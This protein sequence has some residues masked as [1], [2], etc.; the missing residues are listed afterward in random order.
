M[1]QLVIIFAMVWLTGTLN[2]ICGQQVQ[3]VNMIPNA[4]SNET[5][6]DSEPNLAINP[7]TPNQLVGS[8][9]TPNPLGVTS[10]PSAPIFFSQDGGQT[11]VLNAIVPSGSATFP[12]GDITVEF[13][14]TT[15]W[16]YS[17]ILRAPA[18]SGA[19]RTMDIFRTN[20]WVGT[21]L[22][23][24][25][26]TRNGPDQPY[27]YAATNPITGVDGLYVGNNDLS[28]SGSQTAAVDLSTNASATTPTL[29][30]NIIE[31]RTPS[32]QDGP[33]IR[34]AIH[35]SGTIYSIHTQRT[36][37]SG[38]VRTV[39]IV[40][41]RDDNWGGGAS[42][43][44]DLTDPSDGLSGRLAMTGVQLTWSGPQLGQERL[45]DRVAI[46]VDPNNAN[47]VY[48]AW[49]DNNGT[50]NANIHVRR[51]I[52]GGANWS[53]NDL[54]NVNSA[55]NPD[56]AI[57]NLGEVAL[58]YQNLNGTNW[59]TIVERTT[60]D[61]AT[62]ITNTLNSFPDGTP[63]S[64]FLPYIGDYAYL[65][66]QP[67]GKDFLGVFSASND[68]T[69]VRF[70]TVQPTWQRNIN[71]GT[72]S[73]RNLANTANVAVSID[74]FFYRVTPVA[75]NED[76]Y[77]RDWTKT[78]SD[79]DP[80]DEPS[81]ESVF[82]RS[83][84]IWNRRN[85]T[86]GAFN[87][88]DQ[89]SNSNPWPVTSGSNYVYA[90]VHRKN[91]GPAKN[92]NMLFMKSE[93][94]TGSNYE[95]INGPSSFAAL[96]FSALDIQQTMVSG[97]EW[98]LI[99]P[100]AVTANH[101]CIAVEVA[102]PQDPTAN[103][104]LL[105]RA[106]GWSN[107]TDLI[108]L[109]DNNKAQRNLQ[110]YT[111]TDSGEAMSAFAVAHNA[112][113]FKRDMVILLNPELREDGLRKYGM[114]VIGGLEQNESI[115]RNDSLILRNMKPCENRWIELSV[116]NL[117]AVG[118]PAQT[119]IFEERVNEMR[120]NG[121]VMEMSGGK[122]EDVGAE[123]L[124][125]HVFAL[126]RLAK[127]YN[128]RLAASESQLALNILEGNLKQEAYINFLK[129]RLPKVFALVKEFMVSQNNDSFGVMTAGNR[130]MTLINAGK[131][132][133]ASNAHGN[134]MRKFNAYL[135]YLDKSDGS[136][137]DII[138][139]LRW[140]RDVLHRSETFNESKLADESMAKIDNFIE[141][142]NN[143]KASSKDYPPF[144][145]QNLGLWKELLQKHLPKQNFDNYL[146][147]ME[148]QLRD[149][150]KLQ[151]SHCQLVDAINEAVVY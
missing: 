23:A 95:L 61:F 38:S 30:S 35:P 134:F 105:G 77:V 18:A 85:D 140:Y 53:A 133:Q 81:T 9:F 120:L 80:G 118:S 90:R 17:G 2:S 123:S 42:P 52:D 24:Q 102:T 149:P 91:S 8:A 142:Y 28:V 73:L 145:R 54:Y 63:A 104:T 125:E 82:Y 75:L 33:P 141:Q 150:K 45:G 113:L 71:T 62:R 122:I 5:S 10:P 69:P 41:S 132:E 106:P 20:N 19:T 112:A 31:P 64:T 39:N 124:A 49:V 32:G 129:E 115:F 151:K 97:V 3:I 74:P 59:N 68:P 92:V 57:N 76:F 117:P 14:T 58:S 131:W 46:A 6:Q 1:K 50:A 40:V 128:N 101:V 99:D 34:I 25:L 55:I 88:N 44:T 147:L 111:G 66:A 21:T 65:T 109:A 130:V 114:R 56:I 15:S 136:T 7:A 72:N 143:V 116:S 79:S 51:S 108:V 103:P 98:N 93:F 135:S 146:G 100:A 22:M 127:F 67:S 87:G 84:D 60:N 148:Q 121:F 26:S 96:P 4:Q 43:F 107:G 70:P 144:V 86:P 139:T 83:S 137:A 16:L 78:S 37:S 13:G 47:R 11:W 126:Q 29:T 110:V 12:T 48:I 89:P 94:G 27:V 36:A 138:Q 119:Y